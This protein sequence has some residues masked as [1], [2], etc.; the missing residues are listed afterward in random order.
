VRI[1]WNAT[2][3]L[4]V[5]KDVA[6]GGVESLLIR[7]MIRGHLLFHGRK[8]RGQFLLRRDPYGGFN[9]INVVDLEDYLLGV[10]PREMSPSAQPEALKAQAVASRTYALRHAADFVKRGFGLKATE[11]SQVYAGV[12][13]EDPRTTAAVKATRGKV[14]RYGKEFIHAWYSA[15][16]G[17]RTSANEDVWKGGHPQPYA[18][19]VVC[20]YCKTFPGYHWKAEVPFDSLGKR[21]TEVGRGIGRVRGVRFERTASGRVKAA[22]LEGRKRHLELTGNEFRILAG[23]RLVRSLRFVPQDDPVGDALEALTSSHRGVPDEELI[24]R[25]ISGQIRHNQG[26]SLRLE[27]T[28]YGHGVGMCQWGAREMARQGHGW[29]DILHF[30]YRG[31]R[32]TE[33]RD[34]STSVAAQSMRAPSSL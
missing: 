3:K 18:R 4:L 17:G 21:L 6:G 34:G 15:A 31:A 2:G 20:P 16:C 22:F 26:K 25:I 10:L 29:R 13:A 1:S 23:H 9:V 12:E 33:L 8:Y 14:L 27:G 28:G 32:V 7:P 11:G 5:S 30:Y 24:Q 19:S